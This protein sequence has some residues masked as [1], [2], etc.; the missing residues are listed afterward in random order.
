MK[1][2]NLHSKTSIHHELPRLS[3]VYATDA[4]LKY[5]MAKGID[6]NQHFFY[7]SQLR[8]LRNIN[9]AQSPIG[10]IFWNYLPKE[11]QS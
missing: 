10:S 8:P 6:L 3:H 2:I 1:N 5:N 4:L 11:S 9:L 7:F